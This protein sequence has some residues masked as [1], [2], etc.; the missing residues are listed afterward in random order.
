MG[1]RRGNSAP[2]RNRRGRAVWPPGIGRAGKFIGLDPRFASGHAL[3]PGPQGEIPGGPHI[4]PAHGKHQVNI[5][6]P[7]ADAPDTGQYG[8]D[9]LIAPAPQSLKGKFLRNYGS[10]QGTQRFYFRGT[11][12]CR[13]Q[14]GPAS[15]CNIGRIDVAHG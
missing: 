8:A 13:F 9:V 15:A 5:G 6:R 4:R 7:I 2:E 3:P 10:S 14:I 11:Q 12:P 1:A